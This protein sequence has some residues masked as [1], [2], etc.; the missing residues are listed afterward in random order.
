MIHVVADGECLSLIARRYGF[1]DF[2]DLYDHPSNAD[3]K[4]HRPNP[5]VLHPGD[6]VNIPERT[7]KYV[8]VPAGQRHTFQLDRPEKELRVVLHNEKGEPIRS[9]AFV[10]EVGH[11]TVNGKTDGNGLV[12]H[13]VPA[14]EQTL[15]L[16]LGRLNPL[17]ETPDKSVSGV[18]ARLANLGYAPGSGRDDATRA[19][20][21]HFQHDVDIDVTGEIDDATLGKLN[22]VHG[23]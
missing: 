7:P 21:A 20:L 11:E 1:K 9:E 6:K 16:R 4:K 12:K 19:A 8:S 23:S 18:V 17:R 5:N 10:L 15:V 2:H 22:D 3:L 13:A 14:G